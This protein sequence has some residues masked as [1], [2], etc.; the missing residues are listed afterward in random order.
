MDR[1]TRLERL[2]FATTQIAAQLDRVN[3]DADGLVL[4]TDDA[5]LAL[6]GIAANLQ[7]HLQ[8]VLDAFREQETAPPNMERLAAR[9]RADVYDVA[10]EFDADE[11]YTWDGLLLGFLLGAGVDPATA[12]QIV[13]AA[14]T[15]EWPI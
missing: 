2:A 6:G 11:Q 14:P 12:R 13:L 7:N 9:W 8:P 1:Q 5:R 15:E 4:L 10:E 3:A